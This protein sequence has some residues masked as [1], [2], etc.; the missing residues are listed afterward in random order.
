M[1]KQWNTV[2]CGVWLCI[3]MPSSRGPNK[4]RD[5]QRTLPPLKHHM[6]L[7]KMIFPVLY[8]YTP[9]RANGVHGSCRSCA[10]QTTVQYS[11]FPSRG[12]ASENMEPR[13]GGR[14]LGAVPTKKH[15]T[16][17]SPKVHSW[18]LDG[19]QQQSQYARTLILCPLGTRQPVQGWQARICEGI[20]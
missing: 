5:V 7:D 12:L 13:T 15:T 6:K 20:D 11:Y 17:R 4:A 16:L 3:D 2:F 10:T 9:W 18:Q 19:V 14:S 1:W 8:T